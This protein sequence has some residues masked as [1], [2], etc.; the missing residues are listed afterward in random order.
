VFLVPV[1]GTIT[2]PATLPTTVPS[3]S[4]AS[5]NLTCGT[6]E[7][8]V[9][10][11]VAVS[12]YTSLS[13]DPALQC[14]CIGSVNSWLRATNA[15]TRTE[16][17]FIGT[18]VTTFTETISGTTT[19]V[20][21]VLDLDSVITYTDNVIDPNTNFWYGSASSPCVSVP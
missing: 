14:Q 2:Q 3:S 13:T 9:L 7:L 1:N 10:Q 15:P 17:R 19:E 12:V 20:T 16:T 21:T 11:A 8:S 5:G 18:G 4:T 6:I